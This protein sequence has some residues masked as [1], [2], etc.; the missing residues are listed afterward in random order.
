L[1]FGLIPCQLPLSGVYLR[2]GLS[3]MIELV[4]NEHIGDP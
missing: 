1:N 2:C 3:Q 4:R